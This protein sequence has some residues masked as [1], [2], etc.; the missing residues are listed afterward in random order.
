MDKPEVIVDMEVV[1]GS[2]NKCDHSADGERHK[3]NQRLHYLGAI[4]GREDH[5]LNYEFKHVNAVDRAQFNNTELPSVLD[6]ADP[7]KLG[8]KFSYFLVGY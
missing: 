2:S 4:L 6:Y 5:V 7:G 8:D 1:T 3:K